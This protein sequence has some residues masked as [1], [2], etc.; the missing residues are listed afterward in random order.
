MS[1]SQEAG[2]HTHSILALALVVLGLAQA[3]LDLLGATDAARTV[4]ALACSP[5]PGGPLRR[6]T[7]LGLPTTR[8]FVLYADGKALE[9]DPERLDSVRGPAPRRALFRLAL[10]RGPELEAD[11]R[12]R[13]RLAALLDYAFAPDSPVRAELGLDPRRP[14]EAV[15]YQQAL[16]HEAGSVHRIEVGR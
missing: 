9:L 8:V 14:I 2:T 15:Q 4:G 5:A 1:R 10:A 11:P 6:A 3:S 13:A 12:S 16:P 7:D